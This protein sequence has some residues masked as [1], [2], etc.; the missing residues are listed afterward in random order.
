MA[1]YTF[2]DGKA[3]AGLPGW[4]L[5][6]KGGEVDKDHAALAALLADELMNVRDE[7]GDSPWP[8]STDKNTVKAVVWDVVARTF[9]ELVDFEKQAKEGTISI[10]QMM[11]YEALG[12]TRQVE[13]ILDGKEFSAEPG[14]VFTLGCH[15]LF[16]GGDRVVK[17]ALKPAGAIWELTK[18][19][20]YAIAS[21]CGEKNKRDYADKAKVAL[22]LAKGMAWQFI[23]APFVV[24][25]GTA[26]RCWNWISGKG[27]GKNKKGLG[28]RIKAYLLN[29]RNKKGKVTKKRESLLNL[30]WK[31]PVRIVTG[32]VKA[33]WSGVKS[34]FGAIAGLFG[35]KTKSYK[36]S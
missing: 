30:A 11:V 7:N 17:W 6:S 36:L 3:T 14:Y 29:T 27:K 22:R 4:Q 25:K 35:G 12:C 24:L 31:L 32:T 1:T 9:N 28:S 26:K 20:G 10:E 2:N 33:V 5:S 23:K 15:A 34:V 16:M 18:A 13:G 19:A 21:L 8:F